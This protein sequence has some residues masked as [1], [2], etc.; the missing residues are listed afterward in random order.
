MKCRLLRIADVENAT[1]ISSSQI[2]GRVDYA[3]LSYCW[4][5]LQTLELSVNNYI[6]LST[7][8]RVGDLPQTIQEA[9]VACTRLGIQYIWIDCLC[10][11]QDSYLDEDWKKEAATMGLI[12][13]NAVL[14]L[15]MAGS[16]RSS[17]SSYQTRDVNLIKPL[18]ITPDP[19][20]EEDKGAYMVCTDLFDYDIVK[21]PLRKR[22]WVFQEWFLAKQSL[23]FGQI[24]LW[25][26]CREQLANETFPDGIPDDARVEYE[27]PP[28]VRAHTMKDTSL[29][30]RD[31]MEDDPKDNADFKSHTHQAIGSLQ[32]KET[33]SFAVYKRWWEI[34]SQY[35][36]TRFTYESDRVIAF[37]GIAQAFR[38]SHNLSDRYLAGIWQRDFPAG[39]MWSRTP[40]GVVEA[41]R[42]LK[43]KAPS[44]SWMSIDGPYSLCGGEGPVD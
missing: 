30:M 5:G 7:Y 14:N 36:E 41:R 19:D 32:D 18:H 21:C 23:V 38:S 37:S 39:L 40:Q 29:F 15:C 28:I 13:E 10:I 27:P 35:A 1:L 26:H 33:D 42:S 2:D 17:E 11:I 4:G 44:W 12:Y 22:G 8:I 31:K 43:Y 9:I 16:G 24:Q 34:L 6:Q 3:T 25:W 20:D